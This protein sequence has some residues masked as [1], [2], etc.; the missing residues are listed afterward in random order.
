MGACYRLFDQGEPVDKAFFLQL[1]EALQLQALVLL[2]D[3]S[4][5]EICWKIS[6]ASYRQSMW[7]L[8]CTEDNFLDQVVGSPNRRDTMTDLFLTVVQKTNS[9]LR[10]IA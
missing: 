8:K 7:L 9:M 2:E 5:L 3:F 10:C 6:M 1:Q 4:H